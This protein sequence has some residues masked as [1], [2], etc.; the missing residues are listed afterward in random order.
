M[1]VVAIN[2]RPRYNKNVGYTYKNE[3]TEHIFREEIVVL[4]KSSRRQQLLLPVRTLLSEED[5]SCGGRLGGGEGVKYASHNEGKKS[6]PHL[7]P[8]QVTRKT[9]THTEVLGKIRFKF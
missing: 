9:K 2:M 3:Q 6:A 5:I 1:L 7:K 4:Y 8:V